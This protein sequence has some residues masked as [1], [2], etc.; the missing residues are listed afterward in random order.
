M[1]RSAKLLLLTGCLAIWP[2]YATPRSP[3]GIYAVVNVDEY[4]G[5][6]NNDLS[7]PAGPATLADP[8]APVNDAQVTSVETYFVC[9][10]QNL[11]KNSAVSGIH[12]GESWAKLNPN[13]PGSSNAYD[14]SLIDA[15][16]AQVSDWNKNHSTF[17]PKT[18]QL[19]SEPGFNSPGW[20][21][22]ELYSCDFLFGGLTNI[23]PPGTVCGKATFSGFMEGGNKSGVPIPE[24]LPLPWNPTYK[25]AWQAFLT[26]LNVRYGSKST[27]VSICVSGPTA[28]SGEHQRGAS[29]RGLHA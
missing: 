29:D 3:L 20:L 18:V 8:C 16:F 27:L 28:A 12:L 25:S 13:S 22:D 17:P 9:L 24:D 23:P 4:T 5:R 15:L 6:Y 2:A 19:S 14:W 1:K 11:L 10:Y 26:E 7:H 21:L